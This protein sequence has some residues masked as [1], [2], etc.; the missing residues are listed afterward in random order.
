[1]ETTTGDGIPVGPV[2]DDEAIRA[3][4]V[5][6]DPGWSADPRR[7]RPALVVVGGRGAGK[8]TFLETLRDRAER[9]LP[10][11]RVDCADPRHESVPH[12]LSVIAGG[13]TRYRPRYRRLR[14]PRL[15]IGLLVIERGLGS[16]D[17][18]R[19]FER[20]RAEMRTLLRRRRDSG[21]SRRFL[22]EVAGAPWE[23]DVALGPFASALRLPTW[24]VSALIGAGFPP[25]AQRWYGHRDEGHRD[26]PID[27]LLELS[28]RAREAEGAEDDPPGIGD[29]TGATPASPPA[30]GPAEGRGR[31]PVAA[32]EAVRAAREHAR[33]EVAEMLFRAFLADLRDCP[34]RIRRLPTPLVLL[35]NADT[36]AGRDLLHGL[37]GTGPGVEGTAPRAEPLT[38]VATMA[39]PP[40]G[41]PDTTAGVSPPPPPG[42]AAAPHPVGTPPPA[43]DASSGPLSPAPDSAV[44]PNPSGS[45]S[46]ATRAALTGRAGDPPTRPLTHRLSLLSPAE[47]RRLMGTGPAGADRRPARL[48]HD[49]TAGHPEPAALLARVA[50]RWEVPVTGTVAL[51]TEP[52]PAALVTDGPRP[53]ESVE[54]RLV[55]RLL[56]GDGRSDSPALS[57]FTT[58]AAARDERERLWLTHRVELVTPARGE[59]VRRAMGSGEPGWVVLGHLLA[60]RLARRAADHPASPAAV[61]GRLAEFCRERGDRAGELYHRLACGESAAVAAELTTELHRMPGR[62]WLD[63]VYAVVRAPCGVPGEQEL[64]PHDRFLRLLGRSEEV[65]RRRD[66]PAGETAVGESTPDTGDPGRWV[67]HLVAALRVVVDPVGGTDRQYLYE[68]IAHVM[69]QLAPMSPDG[70]VELHREAAGHRRR[71]AWWG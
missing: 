31:R 3:V 22:R 66:G 8:T 25:R 44:A 67:A 60:R 14:F 10:H 21:R 39:S 18:P 40:I 65:T 24:V 20:A 53:P 63:L 54:Q 38:V 4:H 32:G 49:L 30:D 17:G 71:A 57:A 28:A 69:G 15:L 48:V 33:R 59:M 16:P 68:Q 36:R 13:L 2:E 41:Y 42:T 12:A 52:V 9:H 50:A 43:P 46:L 56:P 7:R 51:L 29:T 62:R 45:V 23:M 6:L 19:D 26:R 55:R 70:L 58:C 1:M 5:L 11:V 61:H 35:D 27:V 37:T 47:V 64:P 34:R